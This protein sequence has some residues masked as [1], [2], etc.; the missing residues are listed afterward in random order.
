MSRSIAVYSVCILLSLVVSYLWPV[1][2][3]APDLLPEIFLAAFW[4]WTLSFGLAGLLFGLW[5]A[6][7]VIKTES[8]ARWKLLLLSLTLMAACS[9]IGF[10][11][12]YQQ[13]L[14]W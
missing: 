10:I 9:V 13:G 8:E 6:D 11:N 1:L 14:F 4:R 2:A 5:L 3:G 12:Y 7:A